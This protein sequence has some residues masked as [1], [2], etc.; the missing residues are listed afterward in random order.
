LSYLKICIHLSFIHFACD[1]KYKILGV[2][3]SL[4]L[5]HKLPAVNL[6]IQ[7]LLSADPLFICHSSILSVCLQENIE[8]NESVEKM[9]GALTTLIHKL[10]AANLRTLSLLIH[11]L[12][13][14]ALHQPTNHMSAT[15]LAIVFGPTLLRPSEGAAS[16]DSLM[17]T[18]NQTRIIET[19]ILHVQVRCSVDI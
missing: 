3:T 4:I 8:Q 5:I 9:V 2:L 16:L 13:R 6:R 19:L 7:S 11:H 12:H 1:F 17:D 10:P 15:N 14:V 18:P